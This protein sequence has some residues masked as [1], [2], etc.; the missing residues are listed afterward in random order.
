MRITLK[1]L[2]YACALKITALFN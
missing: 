1:C 2:L